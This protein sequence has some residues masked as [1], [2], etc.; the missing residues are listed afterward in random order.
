MKTS[1]YIIIILFLFYSCTDKNAGERI[2]STDLSQD[3]NLYNITAMIKSIPKNQ[4][5]NSFSSGPK[6]FEVSGDLF[7][8]AKMLEEKFKLEKILISKGPLE[9]TKIY[10]LKILSNSLLIEDIVFDRE[11][12]NFISDAYSIDIQSVEERNKYEIFYNKE[13]EISALTNI[14]QNISVA[15]NKI[16]ISNISSKRFGDLIS[17]YFGIESIRFKAKEGYSIDDTL[18]LNK[19]LKLQLEQ[20]GFSHFDSSIL[21]NV[22]YLRGN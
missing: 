19:D 17:N 4:K 8:L 20:L 13:R 1:T 22:I 5:K 12:F 14:P 2:F 18:F 3:S 21:E 6:Y 16:Y 9:N 15:E 7:Y 10:Y 11:F